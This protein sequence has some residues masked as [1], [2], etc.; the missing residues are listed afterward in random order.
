MSSWY[1]E[2]P[3]LFGSR[4]IT[5]KQ[6]KEL[7]TDEL[8]HAMRIWKDFKRF[9]LPHGCGMSGENAEVIDLLRAFEVEHEDAVC[10]AHEK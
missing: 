1:D 3:L 10:I 5:R 2:Q 4:T 6:L 9:G 7:L 8:W